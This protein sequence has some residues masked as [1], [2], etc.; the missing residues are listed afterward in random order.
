[1]TLDYLDL[2]PYAFLTL[3]PSLSLSLTVCRVKSVSVVTATA[4]CP[5]TNYCPILQVSSNRRN[6]TWPISNIKLQKH[7]YVLKLYMTKSGK[8]INFYPFYALD[9]FTINDHN[10]NESYRR[11]TKVS[12]A[13]ADPLVPFTI[14]FRL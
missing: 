9:Y 7:Y 6:Y 8:N 5:L 4:R 10:K 1:M 13:I 2:Y 12:Q 3:M 14:P 11:K